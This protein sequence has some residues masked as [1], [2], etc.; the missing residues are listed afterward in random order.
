MRSSKLLGAVFLLAGAAAGMALLRRAGTGDPETPLRPTRLFEQVFQ[1]VH[2]FGV[3]SLGETE[4]YRRAADGLLWELDDENATLLAA[5]SALPDLDRPD[6]G[7]LGLLLATRDGIVRVLGVLPESPADRAGLEAGDVLLEVDD[8]PVEASRRDELTT[9]LA[10]APGSPVTLA[11]RRPGIAPLVRARLER[12]IPPGAVVLP[13][14]MLEPGIGYVAV[15]LLGEGGAELVRDAV[16]GLVGA[17][18]R[19]LVLDLRRASSGS[20]REAAALAGLFLP[21]GTPVTVIEGRTH[22]PE[23]VA[24]P[25]APAFGALPLVVV[26]DSGTADAAE[27]VAAV[28]QEQDRALVVGQPTFGRGQ[29]AELFRLTAQSSVR[30]STGRWMTP[31]GRSIQRD[32]DTA[33]SRPSVLTP[34]GRQLVGGGGVTPDSVTATDTLTAGERTFLRALGSSLPAFHDSLRAVGLG[35]GLGPGPEARARLA[36]AAAAL[37]VTVAEY[38]GGGSWIDRELGD[39][40][41]RRQ[42]GT[43]AWLLARAQRDAAVRGAL[44][45]LR[46]ASTAAEVVG[47]RPGA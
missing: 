15:P 5:G 24:T 18:A 3:D 32:P 31:L 10:G 22:S 45:V 42:G 38:T 11:F 4:L 16:G 34:A 33:E 1:Y 19:S 14:A 6:P 27:V 36:A 13:G 29:S 44:A 30:L 17:G 12:G 35:E 23:Q 46:G 43:L 47:L 20:L 25:A 21:K 28:L 7:G 41:A 39:L 26:V 9:M 40:A 8:R 37:G 2:R